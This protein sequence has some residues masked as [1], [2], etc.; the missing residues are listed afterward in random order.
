MINT[1]S[2]VVYNNELTKASPTMKLGIIYDVNKPS[3]PVGI[4]HNLGVSKVKLSHPRQIKHEVTS[5]LSHPHQIEHEVTSKLSH[6]HQ[7]KHE[8]SVKS[9]DDKD[10]MDKYT[11][12]KFGT[13]KHELNLIVIMISAVTIAWLLF[14]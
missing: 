9:N 10:F 13:S 8:I 6:P 4:K 14:R 5:K 1:E 11:P 7:I 3:I 12:V 2:V